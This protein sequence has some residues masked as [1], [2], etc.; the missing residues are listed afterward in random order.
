MEIQKYHQRT[1]GRTDTRT[2]VGARDACASKNSIL[3][4]QSKFAKSCRKKGGLFK[5][6]VGDWHLSVFEMT[7]N[8]LI[9][10]GLIKDKSTS[11]CKPGLGR[12]DPCVTCH[13]DAM[14]T[15][16]DKKTGKIRNTF[17]EKYKKEHRV[18][19]YGN[20]YLIQ[21][22]ITYPAAT[23]S[24]FQ[25]SKTSVTPK[26]DQEMKI[27]ENFREILQNLD[28]ISVLHIL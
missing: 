5:C 2:W 13:T 19:R 6:C 17:I 20:F 7:R 8:M 14:C 27:L 25:Y 28:R 24:D 26:Q 10:E 21:R 1:D 4:E 11:W 12:K 18:M 23:L 15:K 16:M 9:K 3:Q 22:S